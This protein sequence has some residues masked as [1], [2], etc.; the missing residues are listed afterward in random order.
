MCPYLDIRAT[1]QR[2]SSENIQ[3]TNTVS[4]CMS[5]MRQK[6]TICRSICTSLFVD[7]CV[8]IVHATLMPCRMRRVSMPMWRLCTKR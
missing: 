6:I 7:T 5:Q 3:K 4:P 2:I 1:R 8:I